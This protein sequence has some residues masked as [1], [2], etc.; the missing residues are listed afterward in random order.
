M[1]DF[2]LASR[3]RLVALALAVG[4]AVLFWPAVGFQFVNFD[5]NDYVYDNPHVLGGLTAGNV[6]WALTTRAC[7]NWHPLT[8]LSLQLDA[9]LFG[10]GPRGFH[11][12]NVVLHAINAAGVFLVLTRL[13]GSPARSAAAAVLFAVHP[14]RVESVAWVSERK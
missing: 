1:P 9:T 5:D 3:P 12:T 13:T 10:C 14:L 4:T 11:L 7:A 2:A 6:E 8:W